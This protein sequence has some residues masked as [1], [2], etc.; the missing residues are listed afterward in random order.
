MLKQP[1]TGGS[2]MNEQPFPERRIN[3]LSDAQPPSVD[4]QIR[5]LQ[6]NLVCVYIAFLALAIA[7]TAVRCIESYR[8]E[9]QQQQIMELQERVT[10]L[11]AVE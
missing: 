8:G 2:G 4:Q 6:C 7:L 1:G 3:R 10:E 11:E 5:Q 9:S